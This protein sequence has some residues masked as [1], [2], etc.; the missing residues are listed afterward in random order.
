MYSDETYTKEKFVRLM[1]NSSPEIIEASNMGSNNLGVWPPWPSDWLQSSS[2][3]SIG[4][5]S[6]EYHPW[7]C[8]V[9]ASSA[10]GLAGILPLLLFPD[11]YQFQYGSTDSL[12]Y[13]L[14]FAV[15]GL[16]GDVFLHLLPEAWNMA[17]EGGLSESE[18]C[19]HVGLCVLVGIFVFIVVEM[20]ANLGGDKQN[21][22]NNNV[23]QEKQQ[24]TGDR[25][26][27]SN[28]QWHR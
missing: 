28:S 21:T 1:Q 6:V 15:G 4:W 12:S 11:N 20:M 27:E 16:L 24:Q 25:L 14:S 3:S 17:Q 19:S 26:F 5:L 13:L 2:S 10:I 8:S 7:I 23:H 22:D 9:V 18:A